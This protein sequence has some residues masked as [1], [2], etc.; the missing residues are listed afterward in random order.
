F[1]FAG[2]TIAPASIRQPCTR[3]PGEGVLTRF[4]SSLRFKAPPPGDWRNQYFAGSQCTKS[5]RRKNCAGRS[6][7]SVGL[8]ALAHPT[9]AQFELRIHFET[10]SHERVSEYAL[11]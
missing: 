10:Q 5:N 8:T 7:F 9:A 3:I 1:A 11:T 4:D 2:S 6:L